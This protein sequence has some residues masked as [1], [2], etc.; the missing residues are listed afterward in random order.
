MR[1][2]IAEVQAAGGTFGGPFD[3]MFNSP[4]LR[5]VPWAARVFI[6]AAADI[7]IGTYFPQN[8]P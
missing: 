4:L 6:L 2:Y 1:E 8:I 5:N 3:L 7:R